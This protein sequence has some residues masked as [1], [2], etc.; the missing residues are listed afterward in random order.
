MQLFQKGLKQYEQLRKRNAFLVRGRARA[1][2]VVGDPPA[3]IAH[4][5]P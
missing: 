3:D 2:R 4:V 5:F 1:R